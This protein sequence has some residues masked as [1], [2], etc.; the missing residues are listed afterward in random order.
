MSYRAKLKTAVHSFGEDVYHLR[1]P[2]L[3]IAIYLCLTEILFGM[4]CPFKIL[5][6]IDCP[7]CGL[8][9]GSLC[10]L[11]GQWKRALS[12][13]PTSFA[14]VL[15]ILWLLFQRYFREQKKILWEAPVT[16]VAVGT[17]IIWLFHYV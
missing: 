2:I 6:G 8:T 1:C 16:I 9:R 4:I 12:Y 14:W 5:T 13:N 10:V 17:I 11:S 7:G 15:L 3:I